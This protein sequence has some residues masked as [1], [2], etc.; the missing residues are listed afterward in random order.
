MLLTLRKD[1][2]VTTTAVDIEVLKLQ[3]SFYF[4]S[5]YFIF[6]RLFTFQYIWQRNA[7]F[8]HPVELLHYAHNRSSPVPTRLF[9]MQTGISP[10]VL[11]KGHLS[12]TREMAVLPDGQPSLLLYNTNIHMYKRSVYRLPDIT[13]LSLLQSQHTLYDVKLQS[14]LLKDQGQENGINRVRF[15]YLWY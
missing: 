1:N 7:Y 13:S 11:S 14:V 9:V 2:Y 12:I 4:T 8:C 6:E 15:V 5:F 3:I 10:H